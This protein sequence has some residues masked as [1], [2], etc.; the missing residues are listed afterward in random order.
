M[1]NTALISICGV[2][3]FFLMDEMSKTNGARSC[4][5]LCMDSN[6]ILFYIFDNF[7][8]I[9]IYIH[10]KY[11]NSCSGRLKLNVKFLWNILNMC[12][13]N[14]LQTVFFALKYSKHFP[15]QIGANICIGLSF[16]KSFPTGCKEKNGPPPIL[17]FSDYIFALI[18]SIW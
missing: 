17:R 3:T 6:I 14:L 5:V 12:Q 13:F 16:I 7:F 10:L 18:A 11:W 2:H 1:Q 15:K 4:H 8:H 9:C